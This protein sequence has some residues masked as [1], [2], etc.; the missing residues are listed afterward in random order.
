MAACGAGF[1]W[2]RWW[3]LEEGVDVGEGKLGGGEAEFFDVGGEGAE[4]GDVMV[5][6]LGA[7]EIKGAEGAGEGGE[8]AINVWFVEEAVA[9][10]V[11]GEVEVDQTIH[12]GVGSQEFGDAFA[13]DVRA[14]A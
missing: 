12:R 4:V 1:A 6:D 3:W 13:S 7:V 2:G 11:T 9:C 8:E 5:D 10:D 14:A